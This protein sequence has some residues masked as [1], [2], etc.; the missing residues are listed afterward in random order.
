MARYESAMLKSAAGQYEAAT[1]DLEQLVKDDPQWLEPHV[2]LAS[3]YYKLR[4]P[5]DGAK[6]R[7]IVDRIAAE[8]QSHGPGK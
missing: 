1:L 8:Q 5:Q 6:E 2:E 7:E 4:R 3:L